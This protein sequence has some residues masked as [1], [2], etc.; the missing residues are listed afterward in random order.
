MNY[1]HLS[2]EEILSFDANFFYFG[3]LKPTYITGHRKCKS[4]Q[5]WTKKFVTFQN[6]V[7]FTHSS[8]SLFLYTRACRIENIGI[9]LNYY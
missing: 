5:H 4:L 2:T 3:D 7:F 1:V 9:I 6:H 8:R